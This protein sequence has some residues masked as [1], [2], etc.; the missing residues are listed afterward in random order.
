MVLEIASTNLVI[1]LGIIMALL[2]GWRF[3]LGEFVGGPVMIVLI[4]ILFRLFLKRQLVEEAR[5][6]ADKGRLGLMEGHAEMDMSVGGEG[7]WWQ[8][9][10]TPA[11]FTPPRTTS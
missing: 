4:A 11:G 1:E 3:V 8:R 9:L 6:E 5:A 7:S 10:R 2:P